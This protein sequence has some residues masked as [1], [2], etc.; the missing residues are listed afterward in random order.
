MDLYVPSLP[1]ISHF[2]HTTPQLAQMTV[3][4]FL[5]GYGLG[6]LITGP[7]SDS[8]GRQ[9]LLIGGLVLCTIIPVM[10]SMSHSIQALLG[11][12]L[13]QGLVMSAP[14]AL[15]R[16][17]MADSFSGKRLKHVV[18]YTTTV[19]ALGPIVAPAIG[20]YL[21]VYFGWQASL[22]SLGLYGLMLLIVCLIFL[23]ETNQHRKPLVIK[24]KIN[25]MGRMLSNSTFMALAIILILAYG[26]SLTFN[27]LGPFLVQHY[28]GYSAI[29]FGHLAMIIGLGW[30]SGS[31]LNRLLS[32]YIS[33]STLLKAGAMA[34]LFILALFAIIAFTLP[35]TLWTLGAPIFLLFM[36]GSLCFT[37]CFG[38]LIAL[39]P[40][41]S[42]TASA[43]YGSLMMLGTGLITYLASLSHLTSQIPLITIY[44]L[45]ALGITF[46]ALYSMRQ[47][48]SN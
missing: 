40:K 6:Q 15:V 4:M 48:Q 42:G 45:F 13:A 14:G 37:N 29:V 8:L 39:Y 41:H 27:V 23:P 25:L 20:G 9:K 22:I 34:A 5:I 46:A 26:Y 44:S 36:T 31:V 16:T 17:I 24:H 38:F 28:M 1:A 43:L 33:H 18:N 35:L 12:R 19:W 3:P 7:L 32:K 2:F 21:Q 30:L 10:A 47:L 11:W